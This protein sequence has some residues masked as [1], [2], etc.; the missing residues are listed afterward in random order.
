[1]WRSLRGG[2]RRSPCWMWWVAI[3]G[4]R[5][6]LGSSVS[7][8]GGECGCSMW[9]SRVEARGRHVGCGGSGERGEVGTSFAAWRYNTPSTTR[10]SPHPLRAHQVVGICM[11]ISF[12]YSLIFHGRL[13]Y[14]RIDTC[15]P[16]SRYATPGPF[17]RDDQ[18]VLHAAIEITLKYRKHYH[19]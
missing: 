15:I 8:A 13:V 16:R 6:S 5:L 14:S 18:T 2:A 9:S 7:K 10:T 17:T 4:M 11:L 1:M 19:E 3:C 12:T